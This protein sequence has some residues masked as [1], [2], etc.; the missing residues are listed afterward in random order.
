MKNKN[1]RE[2]KKNKGTRIK[3]L[4]QHRTL[5]WNFCQRQSCRSCFIN[6]LVWYISASCALTSRRVIQGNVHHPNVIYRGCTVHSH[7]L[8]SILI[9]DFHHRLLNYRC[10]NRIAL[11]YQECSFVIFSIKIDAFLL[12][13]IKNSLGK[14]F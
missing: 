8:P 13:L 5:A 7:L 1:T 4:C 2:R 3:K 11:R 14:Y 9:Y 12:K 10:D 6:G